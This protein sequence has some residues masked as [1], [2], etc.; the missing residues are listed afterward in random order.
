V[1]PQYENL[2]HTEVSNVLSK[3]QCHNERM[4]GFDKWDWQNHNERSPWFWHKL[5]RDFAELTVA[6]NIHLIIFCRFA[7]SSCFN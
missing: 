7:N 6:P 5:H 1:L 2:P 4:F 3:Y